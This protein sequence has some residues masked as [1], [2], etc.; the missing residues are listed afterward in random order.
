MPKKLSGK[1]M[2]QREN[3]IG[4]ICGNRGVGKST[5]LIEAIEAHPK[6]VLVYDLDDNDKYHRYQLISPEHLSRWKGG[7]KRIITPDTDLVFNTLVEHTN[8]A[9]LIFEDA[10]K[11]I[12][13][14]PPKAIRQLVLASKQ[15]NLDIFF[16]FHTYRSIPPKLFSWADVLE[17]FKTGE[18]ISQFK[19][20]IPQFER[21]EKVHA[22]VEKHKNRFFHKTVR[23]R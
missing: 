20:K 15:R 16:T 19:N 2:Q 13:S 10:T 12:D 17:V 5:F 21:V 22:E 7:V 18:D 14:D 4:I 6:K 23:L 3:I 11:Y 8:N 9:L 1:Q